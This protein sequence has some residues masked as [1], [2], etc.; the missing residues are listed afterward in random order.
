[1]VRLKCSAQSV[2]L[3]HA[4]DGFPI[5]SS[6]ARRSAHMSVV[7]LEKIQQEIPLK[8]FHRLL[9]GLF[10]RGGFRWSWILFPQG[11]QSLG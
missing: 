3:D 5:H 2:L 11:L 1:M 8:S 10:E 6:L 7:A 4:L 9:L